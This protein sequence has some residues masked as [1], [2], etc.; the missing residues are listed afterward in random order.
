VARLAIYAGVSG[1]LM[2]ASLRLADV[3]GDH[4]GSLGGP[5]R[6]RSLPG[7][8]LACCHEGISWY[9]RGGPG[10]PRSAASRSTTRTGW[11]SA[12]LRNGRRAE[13]GGDRGERGRLRRALHESRRSRALQPS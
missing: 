1:L 12:V 9:R 8:T 4:S 7:L 5:I 2:A 6:S 10:Y 13:P 3:P 11:A